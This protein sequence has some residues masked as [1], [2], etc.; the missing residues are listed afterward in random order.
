MAITGLELTNIAQGDSINKD[1]FD[2]AAVQV[3]GIVVGYEDGVDTAPATIELKVY[4]ELDQ[5]YSYQTYTVDNLVV[6]EDGTFTGTIDFSDA[7]NL[8]GR[9]GNNINLDGFVWF[10]ATDGTFTSDQRKVQ[11]DPYDSSEI[12]SDTNATSEE[13]TVVLEGTMENGK[14]V[15]LNDWEHYRD[16]SSNDNG[17]E[18]QHDVQ[19]GWSEDLYVVPGTVKYDGAT[20]QLGTLVLQT[21]GDYTYTLD[22]AKAQSLSAGEV[23]GDNF[24]FKVSDAAGNMREESL[25]ISVFGENDKSCVC[26]VE[27]AGVEGDAV[28]GGTTDGKT[29]V[30]EGVATVFKGQLDVQDVDIHDGH[31]FAVVG[32]VVVDSACVD[33]DLLTDV[34][35]TVNADGSV[36]LDGNFDALGEGET[37]T[38]TFQYQATDFYDQNGNGVMDGNE[39]VSGTSNIA[40]ATITVTGTNDQIVANYDQI[41]TFRD[42][43]TGNIYDAVLRNDTDLDVN[44]K[45]YIYQTSQP[46]GGSHG[47]VSL[48][49]D[50]EFLQYAPAHKENYDGEDMYFDAF[51]Y[52]VSDRAN[53]ANLSS[54]NDE[55]MVEV[56]VL[57]ANLDEKIETYIDSSSGCVDNEYCGT[58]AVEDDPATTDVDE[59]RSGNDL[60]TAGS[61]NDSLYGQSGHDLLYGGAGQDRILG[62]EGN[63]VLYGGKDADV[64]IGGEGEDIFAF[65]KGDGADIVQDYSDEDMIALGTTINSKDLAFFLDD[66]G[67]AD[68]SD[69]KLMIK[70]SQDCDDVITVQGTDLD[71]AH[72]EYDSANNMLVDIDVAAVIDAINTYN[73]TAGNTAVT[74]VCEVQNNEDLMATIAAAGGYA[75]A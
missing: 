70:Y 56:A 32:D 26:D 47:V 4:A 65:N 75:G 50:N 42:L 45:K 63:D 36:Q 68:T 34:N 57:S 12:Y 49:T 40:T 14:N 18:V 74:N 21:N 66:N 44:D 58:K 8:T 53:H 51:T 10:E 17:V 62:Q 33:K 72:V 11:F 2:S 69:D 30:D 1:E 59:T 54:T 60:I 20:E 73:T 48:N 25:R 27:L 52:Q 7:T 9:D 67:T 29:D 28:V 39:F 64:L 15:L 16:E 35:L 24:T 13:S 38:V 41:F 3:E 37:A 5:A 19:N 55:A 43:P 23:G 61:G 71:S 6:A 31:A 22:N 46:L